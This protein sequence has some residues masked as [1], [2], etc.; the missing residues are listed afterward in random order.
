[1]GNGDPVHVG[2]HFARAAADL[3][4]PLRFVDVREA[5]RGGWLQRKVNWWIRGKRPSRLAE[6]SD[7]VTAACATR[8]VE[9]VIATG[10]APLN[11]DCLRALKARG[12]RTANFLTDDPWNRAH[13]ADWF[14]EALGQYD[15]VFTPRRANAREIEA[16]GPRVEFLPFAY[17]PHVHYPV[18]VSAEE[19]A[20]LASDVLFAGGAD[21]DRVPLVQ[22]LVSSGLKVALYGGY[23]GRFAEFRAFYRG[24]A[25]P[26]LLRKA[27]ASTEIALC[28]VR[29]ANRDGNSMRT[30]EAP[31]M[32]ACLLMER[33]AEHEEIFGRDGE[34]VEYF[35]STGELLEKARRLLGNEAERRRLA[36]RAFE[37]V[38]TG[39][40]TYGDRLQR[41]LSVMGAMAKVGG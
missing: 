15:W 26:E 22:A 1:V 41:M 37:L 2:A 33:T 35:E 40:H 18:E 11:R 20:A 14:L 12:V 7:A 9:C 8:E 34:A 6:F 3:G 21:P 36:E 28:L 38:T 27:M 17:A 16:A 30:F 13:R 32:R 39:G 23:W 10:I 31:A 4:V 24:M 5:Y 25:D 19:R 29:K